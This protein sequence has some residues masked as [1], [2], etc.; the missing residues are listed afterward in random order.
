MNFQ[1]NDD[2]ELLSDTIPDDTMYLGFGHNFN[3]SVDMLPPLIIDLCFGHNFN[4][5][6]NKLPPSIIHLNFYNK[7]LLKILHVSNRT[8]INYKN[9]EDPGYNPTKNNVLKM[10][11]H[12]SINIKSLLT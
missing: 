2:I 7:C 5:S 11:I 3:Q 12:H 6:V 1:Y 9:Y 10:K 8:H 4:Q